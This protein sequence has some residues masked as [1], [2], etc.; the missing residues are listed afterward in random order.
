MRV[1]PGKIYIRRWVPLDVETRKPWQWQ[2]V[3]AA[4]AGF[5]T[6]NCEDNL[7]ASHSAAVLGARMHALKRHGVRL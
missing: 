2:C 7:V 3:R 6:V 4:Y 5:P 1:K